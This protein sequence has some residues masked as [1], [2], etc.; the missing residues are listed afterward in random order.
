MTDDRAYRLQRAL[1]DNIPDMAWLKD[2]ESR[3]LGVSGAYLETLGVSEAEVIGKRPDEIWPLEIAEVYLR[4]DRAVL[5]SGKRR[6]YEESRRDPAGALRWFDT[7][8]SP[9]RDEA[10]RIVGTVG[11]SRDITGRKAVEAELRESRAQLRKLSGIEQKA[12][13][14]ERA[15]I[16]R[17]LH[18]EL[19]QTLTAIKM[20]LGWLRQ[21]T[22]PEPAQTVARVSRL[23]GVVDQ[24]IV[25]LRRIATELRPLMLDELGL[26]AAIE[27][28]AQSVTERTGL[29]VS[30]A[31]DRAAGAYEPEIGTAAFRIVQEALTNAVRHGG[32]THA[33]VAVRHKGG[34]LLI[35]IGDDGKGIDPTS[36]PRGRLGLAGMRERA[37][38]AGGSVEIEGRPKRGTTVSLRLPLVRRRKRSP[39][40]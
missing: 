30:V 33:S 11:I 18:D 15:R 27:W 32:A 8:K 5:R 7:I 38:L 20:E 10:G 1:L 17:E 23:I 14:E 39:R 34:D 37:R 24:A 28:L 12:R 9:I 35:V 19:G 16:A 2:R 31:F 36:S 4:T 26:L 40:S 22:P 3:Y 21:R 13:E 6:R 29:P 25:D